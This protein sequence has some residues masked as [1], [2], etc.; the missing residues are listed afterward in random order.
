M[1]THDYTQDELLATW[2]PQALLLAES[3][4]G[5]I[6]ISQFL[7]SKGIEQERAQRA[8]EL[9]VAEGRKNTARAAR[10]MRIIGWALILIGIFIPVATMIMNRGFY[11][12]T[13]FPIAVGSAMVWGDL[14]D[15]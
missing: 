8:A 1:K 11:A 14:R 13:L 10:P 2:R 9:L 4:K 7:R 15:I 5:A 6:T 12:V 3:G